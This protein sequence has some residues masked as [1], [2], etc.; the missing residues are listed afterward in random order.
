MGG[1]RVVRTDGDI[2]EDGWPAWCRRMGDNGTNIDAETPDSSEQGITRVRF[3]HSSLHIL[4]FDI[5]ID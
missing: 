1:A 5:C 4:C 2:G 3:L